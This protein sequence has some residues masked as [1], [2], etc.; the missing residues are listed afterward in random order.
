MDLRDKLSSLDVPPAKI[1][2][3]VLALS[4]I[5]LL[6]WLLTLSHV[7]YNQ[8]PEANQFMSSEHPVDTTMVT[9][10]SSKTKEIRSSNQS[11]SS[12]FTNG[13]V[14]FFVLLVILIMVW[15]WLDRKETNGS[16][17]ID[18]QLGT[19]NLGEGAQ[20]RIIRLNNEIWV[21]GVTSSSVNLLHRYDESDWAEKTPEEEVGST[22]KFRKL[23]KNH[24]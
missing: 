23:F 22:D 13:L 24:L 5:L 6:I 18:R 7:D 3:V 14:T 19:E 9:S 4:V 8:G 12:M 16:S 15:V 20:L 21:L 17:A 1:L 11:S 2:K 10:D